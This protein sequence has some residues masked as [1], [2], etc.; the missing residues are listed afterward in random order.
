M[1][2][3]TDTR[4]PPFEKAWLAYR[5]DRLPLV[6]SELTRVLVE[7]DMEDLLYEVGW[8]RASMYTAWNLDAPGGK[9]AS[10][11]RNAF[12]AAQAPL[13]NGGV[14]SERAQEELLLFGE[15]IE[16]TGLMI[17]SQD[18]RIYRPDNLLIETLMGV[19]IKDGF[20]MS[21]F[22]HLDHACYAIELPAR[23]AIGVF[24]R[25]NILVVPFDV[26]NERRELGPRALAILVDF[27]RGVGF[28]PIVVLD[29]EG[30]F[31]LAPTASYG[32]VNF[33]VFAGSPEHEAIKAESEAMAE[34]MHEP[35]VQVVH[36][37]LNLLLYLVG[38]DDV[39]TIVRG[40]RK[41][42]DKKPPVEAQRLRE[43]QE[44]H[45]YGFGAKWGRSIQHWIKERD[46]AQA[47]A[48]A[49]QHGGGWT[50]CPHIRQAHQH[51]YW[52]GPGKTIPKVKFLM[53]ILVHKDRAA[54]EG[55]PSDDL[56]TIHAVH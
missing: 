55:S 6:E 30:G 48:P 23:T 1:I 32:P 53:P 9:A 44:P 28:K 8:A 46:S 39:T 36:L 15:T 47:S 16:A 17:Y 42:L 27:G 13:P 56:P 2:D 50:V 7:S 25:R 3:K 10:A 31:D 49:G 43:L 26:E 29:L 11:W 40:A 24:N 45:V 19:E 34:I 22:R 51:L 52:T 21:L 4:Y 33:P 18:K 54:A 5:R 37:V 14:V 41:N 20:P 12:M 38:Q 35:T